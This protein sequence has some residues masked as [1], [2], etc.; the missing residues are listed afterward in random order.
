MWKRITRDKQAT[1]GNMASSVTDLRVDLNAVL[2]VK[3]ERNIV[4]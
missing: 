4:S 3:F 1:D 2:S